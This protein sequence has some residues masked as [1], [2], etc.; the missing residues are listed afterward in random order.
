MNG[1]DRLFFSMER[2]PNTYNESFRFSNNGIEECEDVITYVR[3]KCCSSREGSC[4][5]IEFSPFPFIP[6]LFLFPLPTSLCSFLPFSVS[7]SHPFIR[8]ST[9][10]S[11]CFFFYS[12]PSSLPSFVSL[13][14]PPLLL[15]SSPSFCPLLPPFLPPSSVSQFALSVSPKDPAILVDERTPF[16]LD[17][18]F[19]EP[20]RE[21]RNVDGNQ[22]LV[23]F[24]TIPRIRTSG[25]SNVSVRSV[26]EACVTNNNET[27][28]SAWC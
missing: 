20:F 7:L 17:I 12:S 4:D 9:P 18:T 24:T 28:T 27:F 2:S 10:S 16:Q 23:D 6:F 5:F 19:E 21:N 14:L 1:E 25:I 15:S 11:I 26:L 22:T 8:N 13:L 3:V